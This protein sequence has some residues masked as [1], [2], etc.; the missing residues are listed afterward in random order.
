M[1]IHDTMRAAGNATGLAP[2]DIGTCEK[3]MGQH[4]KQKDCRLWKPIRPPQVPPR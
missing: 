1:N 4:K 3:H 2:R